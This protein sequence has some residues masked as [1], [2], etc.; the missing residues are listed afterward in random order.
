MRLR[1]ALPSIAF[2]L[3]LALPMAW[4]PSAHAKGPWHAAEKNTGGWKYMTPEERIEHQRRMRS[5]TRYAECKAYQDQ[6]RALMEQRALEQDGVVLQHRPDSGCEQL[7]A[8]GK[9]K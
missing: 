2:G 6:H 4:A 9:L 3:A 7:R 8:R 5:F 1:S